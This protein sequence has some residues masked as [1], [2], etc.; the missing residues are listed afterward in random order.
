MARGGIEQ[1]SRAM[2]RGRAPYHSVLLRTIWRAANAVQD[3]RGNKEEPW[4][5]KLPFPHLADTCE[6]H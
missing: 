3:N 1:G 5:F 6:N 4:L 2:F